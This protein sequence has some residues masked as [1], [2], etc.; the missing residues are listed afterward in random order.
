MARSA[1]PVANT[2]A[3]IVALVVN[4]MGLNVALAVRTTVQTAQVQAGLLRSVAMPRER[5]PA[6]QDGKPVARTARASMAAR[7]RR[8]S[9]SYG[10]F[11][12][13]SAPPAGSPVTI[14]SPEAG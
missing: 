9:N 8:G 6:V 1:A 14:R 5:W 2:R 10:T 11:R 13:G 12:C 4:T 3:P 7:L